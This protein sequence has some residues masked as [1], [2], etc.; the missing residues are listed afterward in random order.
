MTSE[1]NRP[2]CGNVENLFTI[3]VTQPRTWRRTLTVR[4]H[5]TH[6]EREG[7][8]FLCWILAMDD[9]RSCSYDIELKRRSSEC[10]QE[11]DNLKII[12]TVLWC[13]PSGTTV[14]S[15]HREDFLESHLRPTCHAIKTCCVT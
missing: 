13:V 1:E 12:F 3:L 15:V 4:V 7:E 14:N 6:Y 9:T 8:I 5:V 11:Q 2:A 10:R